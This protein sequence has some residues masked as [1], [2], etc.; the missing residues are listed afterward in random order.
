MKTIK[1]IL[2][3]FVLFLNTSL[4]S[5]Q[6]PEGYY[7]SAL[8][9]FGIE[10]KQ[11]LH[12]IID[13]HTVIDYSELHTYFQYTDKKPN[14]NVWDMYSDIPDGTPPYEYVFLE[15]TCGNY[16]SENDCYNKEHS[17]PKSWFNDGAPMYSDMFHLY[18][19]DGYVNGR[20]SNYPYGEV[21]TATWTSMNGSKVGSCVYPGYTGVVFEPIDAYKGDFARSY[22]YMSVR[23]YGEDAGWVGSDMVTGAEL[24]PWAMKMMLEWSAA[25][26][27]SQKEIDR[28]NSVYGFQNNRNPFIDNPEYALQIWRYNEIDMELGSNQVI[29]CGDSIQMNPSIVY[30]DENELNFEWT[31]TNGLNNTSIKNPIAKP[32]TTTTYYLTATSTN[33]TEKIDSI[34]IVVNSDFNL[35]FS[36]VEDSL[37]E[38]P[39]IFE[40]TNTTSNIS[41]YTFIWNFENDSVFVNNNSNF[42]YEFFDEGLY[43]ISMSAVN[44]QTG[45]EDIIIKENYLYAVNDTVSDVKIIKKQSYSVYPNPTRDFIYLD[46]ENISSDYSVQIINPLGQTVFEKRT[47]DSKV[48]ID[49]RSFETAGIYLISITDISTNRTEIRKIVFEVLE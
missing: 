1:T 40:I 18:P 6:I 44:N 38:P 43:T 17:W 41:D 32:L 9:L 35:E 48:K 45:C 29:T 39:Y 37:F 12:E 19:T 4:L 24:K 31:P 47:L 25:D 7:D 5:A 27:V 11:A 49:L 26:P 42:S 22:F 16:N 23:Y 34:I 13:S 33:G 28:N 20:R 30:Y 21:N 2:L 36:A 46:V 8:G 14:G 10:L 15:R 3:Y